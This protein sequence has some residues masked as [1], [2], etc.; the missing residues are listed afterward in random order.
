MISIGL[1]AESNF[2]TAI[3]SIIYQITLA[4]ST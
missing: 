1:K 4:S 2:R 3:F